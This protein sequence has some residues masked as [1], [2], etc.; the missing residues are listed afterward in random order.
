MIDKVI[1]CACSPLFSSA[2]L[3]AST[4]QGLPLFGYTRWESLDEG[5]TLR[6]VCA[7][8]GHEEETKTMSVPRVGFEAT[9]LVSSGRRQYTPYTRSA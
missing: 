1:L 7:C 5:P 6:K 4:V 2:A 8:T 9:I 3:L